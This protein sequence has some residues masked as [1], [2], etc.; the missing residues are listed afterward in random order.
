MPALADLPCEPVLL[1]T[2]SAAASPEFALHLRP[3]AQRMIVDTS[4]SIVAKPRTLGRLWKQWADMVRAVRRLQ[5]DHLY[6]AY[7]DGLVQVAGLERLAGRRPWPDRTEAEVLLLRGGYTYGAANLYK[8][9]RARFSPGLIRVGPWERIHHLIEEDLAV[10]RGAGRDMEQRCRL[11][12]DPVEPASGATK[13]EARR[14][15]GIPESGRYIGCAGMM[16]TRKGIDR[17]LAAF[18]SAQPKLGRDDRLLLAG[19]VAPEIRS[20]L[21]HEWTADAQRN[22]LV[23]VD[24]QLSEAE[25]NLAVAALDIV[26]TP[27]PTH[28]HS[29]SIVIRA[30]AAERPVLGSAIGWMEHTIRRFR[31]GSVCDVTDRDTF[32]QAIVAGLDASERHVPTESSRRFA[33]FHSGQNFAAHWTARIRER[34]GMPPVERIEWDWVTAAL[35]DAGC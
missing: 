29:A 23:G 16:D 33:A 34:L 15:L 1:T 8:Q 18:Q 35:T 12:P 17:L 20:L 14:A 28:I 3:H 5:P 30:A 13:T 21:Q 31:L 32:A 2:P 10:L 4:I 11:M 9:L 27:Y 22:C 25:M 6:V 7:G 19:P 24:R 26:C